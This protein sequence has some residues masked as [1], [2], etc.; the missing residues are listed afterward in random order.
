MAQV[1]HALHLALLDDL[2]EIAVEADT[3]L[4]G[5][6]LGEPM[7][8]H[9]LAGAADALRAVGVDGEQDALEIVGADHAQ[10]AFDELAIACFALAQG[11]FCAALDGDVD[12]GGDDEVDLALVVEQRRGR[13]GDAAQAAVAMQPLVLERDGE[14]IGAQ[15]LE[16]LDGGGDVGVG[17]E[18][19]PE[20][21][22]DQGGEVVSGGGLAGAVEANDA[23]GG[24]ED[25]DQCVDG[26]EHGGDEVA[27]DDE[28]GFDALAGAGNA[29]HLAQGVVEFDRGHGLAAE[30]G[31]SLRWKGVSLREGASSTK[32][33]PMRT[34][35][36]VTSG[37]PA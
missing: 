9:V 18:L 14:A 29:L 6:E 4:L 23:A 20:I 28:G 5:H 36:G 16:V 24:V 26:V 35:V 34:P 13:P 1:E 3:A 22:A 19:V 37:A 17:D 2:A 31:E 7:A 30:H 12:A 32:S 8:G 11:V 33:A 15:A 25:G 27:L 21:A 10:R